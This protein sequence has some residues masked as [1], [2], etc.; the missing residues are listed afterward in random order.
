MREKKLLSL[1]LK[2]EEISKYLLYSKENSKTVVLMT[3]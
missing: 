2:I 3:K 1:Q